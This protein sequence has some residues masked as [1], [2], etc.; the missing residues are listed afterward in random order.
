MPNVVDYLNWRGDVELTER[1]FNDVDNL[2]LATLSY[3]DFGGIVP[4]PGEGSIALGKACQMVMDE[5]QSDV[6]QRVRSFAKLTDKF[7]IAL[8]A[9]R[10]FSSMTLHGYVDE[11]DEEKSLQFSAVQIDVDPTYTYVS[12]RGTDST[13]VGWREDFMLSF[14]VPEAQLRADAYLEQAIS[15]VKEQGRRVYVGGHSKGGNLAVYAALT[16]DAALRPLISCVWSNDGPGLAPEIMPKSPRSQ[17]GYRY[18]RIVPAYDMVGVIF[19]RHDD[20]RIVV[21]SNVMGA[22]QHDPFTW[23]V[24]A[25]GMVTERDLTHESKVIKESID[26]WIK[27]IPL[28]QRGVVVNQFFDALEAGG[29]HKMSEVMENRQAMSAV[30]NAMGDMDDS[31]KGLLLSFAGV[32]V[33]KAADAAA[34]KAQDAAETA[35]KAAFE[36][37]QDWRERQG[38]GLEGGIAGKLKADDK[39]AQ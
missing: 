33:Q 4:P 38:R 7:L 19:E 39:P 9:S 6:R 8:A 36:A 11:L 1:P 2:I 3:L 31:T 30:L 12:Y 18:R 28:D 35:L 5:T 32:V 16:C 27:G 34:S 26:T 25:F 24:D 20:P 15:E 10:R 37:Y 22:G 21:K 23:Q 29:A 14:T 13:L 17:L